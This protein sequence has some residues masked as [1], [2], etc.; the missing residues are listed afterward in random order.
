L[1]E[2]PASFV[3]RLK[4]LGPRFIRVGSK[5]KN[6]VDRAWQKPE[7]WMHAND[8]ELQEWLGGEE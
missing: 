6:P 2:I 4:N 8:P 1:P 5:S 3:E 7:N